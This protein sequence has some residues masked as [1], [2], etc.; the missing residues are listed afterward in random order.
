MHG[1]GTNKEFMKMQTEIL[2]KD[3]QS[4]AELYYVD[5]P[6][7]VPLSIIDDPKVVKNIVG[8]P[9]SWFNFLTNGKK[10][11]TQTKR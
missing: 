3:L 8:K 7:L 6:Y 5:A 9:Y 2:R 10:Q 1:F 11:I 4:I